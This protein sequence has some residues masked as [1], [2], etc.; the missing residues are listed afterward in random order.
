V[1]SADDQGIEAAFR[2]MDSTIAGL[3]PGETLLD[4]AARG[5]DVIRENVA[6]IREAVEQADAFD[7]IELMRLRETP[8][9]LDGYRES[10]ADQRPAAEPSKKLLWAV[11]RSQGGPARHLRGMR[12]AV[13]WTAARLRRPPVRRCH[14]H[15]PLGV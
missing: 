7:V 15:V 2:S 11:R 6:A 10:L 1:I 4:L 9:V 3:R 14:R 13:G 8:L 12:L 5:P